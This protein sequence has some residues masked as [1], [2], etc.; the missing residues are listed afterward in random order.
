MTRS[1]SPKARL[2]GAHLSTPAEQNKAL[3]IPFVPAEG[4]CL[5]R[6][7]NL[8][9]GPRL[10]VHGNRSW[11]P[12][13]IAIR[14]SALIT[15][16]A[17][18]SSVPG[19]SPGDSVADGETRRHFPPLSRRRCGEICQTSNLAGDSQRVRLSR[20]NPTKAGRGRSYDV[21]AKYLCF[22]THGSRLVKI[23]ASHPTLMKQVAFAWSQGA[24]KT[25]MR[26]EFI[27]RERHD[28]A[29]PAPV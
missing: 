20:R 17:N 7:T 11:L 28:W 16:D 18:F 8:K 27:H 12:S 13:R 22:N 5:W 21:A 3:K 26:L 29:R 1:V 6:Q 19:L 15:P 24:R 9:P 2:R 25:I 10:P 4:S 23:S 14:N